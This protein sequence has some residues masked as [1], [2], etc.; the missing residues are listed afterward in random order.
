MRTQKTWPA[1]RS[2]ETILIVIAPIETADHI[3]GIPPAE[4]LLAQGG[5][6]AKPKG[7]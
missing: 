2:S 4:R 3:R 5:S 6:L 1:S 7:N